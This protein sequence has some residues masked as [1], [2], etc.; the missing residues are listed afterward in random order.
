MC[1]SVYWVRHTRT[2]VAEVVE[3]SPP[4]VPEVGLE[5]GPEALPALAPPQAAPPMPSPPQ[6]PDHIS[7]SKIHQQISQLLSE[8]AALTQQ[9]IELLRRRLER[10]GAISD[11]Q[12]EALLE[13]IKA[14]QEERRGVLA[15]AE[16]LKSEALQDLVPGIALT[17]EVLKSVEA[18]LKRHQIQVDLSHLDGHPNKP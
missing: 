11:Q 5:V 2:P 15:A 3:Q 10:D 6:M 18:E 9:K 17:E 4:E 13:K 16:A 1:G 8:Q 12:R 14:L 7:G